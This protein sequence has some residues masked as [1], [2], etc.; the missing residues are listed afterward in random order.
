MIVVDE[1]YILSQNLN[2]KWLW[3]DIQAVV[4]VR[5]YVIHPL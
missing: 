5:K 4:V 1:S 2:V 3:W